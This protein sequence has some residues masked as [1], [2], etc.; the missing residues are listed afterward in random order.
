MRMR[1]SYESR[2]P[3][4]S[5]RIP[6]KRK[7]TIQQTLEFLASRATVL[8]AV[9]A[10]YL[11]PAHA[12]QGVHDLDAGFLRELAE[13]R[14]ATAPFHDIEKAIEAGWWLE[15]SPCEETALGGMGHHY[16]N[17]DLWFSG[18]M[19]DV[20]LPQALFYEPQK[21]GRMRLVGVEYIVPVSQ[22]QQGDPA[23]RL[24]DREFHF[25]PFIPGGG[26][27]TLHVWI[28]RNNPEG[29]F[30]DWNPK[31]SCQYAQ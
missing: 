30:A 24:F 3:A 2:L 1:K 21:N 25:N 10:F 17:L 31:V 6:W 22:F 12:G 28:W 15:A 19:L 26:A 7:T 14:Q 5:R 20:T 4:P 27:W 8:A 18:G 9:L 11:L 16:V 13:A 23:P 29:T